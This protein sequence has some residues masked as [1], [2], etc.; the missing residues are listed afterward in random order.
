M[1]WNGGDVFHSAAGEGKI[2]PFVYTL[3]AVGTLGILLKMYPF[4]WARVY[5]KG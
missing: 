4:P 1:C 3:C 2:F 5:V